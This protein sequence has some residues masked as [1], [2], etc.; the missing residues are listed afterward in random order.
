METGKTHGADA[1]YTSHL[2]ET[3]SAM[4]DAT[5]SRRPAGWHAT[6]R[7]PLATR[8]TMRLMAHAVP[9]ETT[10]RHTAPH[11]ARRG[12]AKCTHR[13]RV[14]GE[15]GRPTTARRSFV[16]PRHKTPISPVHVPSTAAAVP[17]PTI[18]LLS[19]VRQN[20]SP[21]PRPLRAMPAQVDY[22]PADAVS[23]TGSRTAASPRA[24]VV[25]AAG[26]AGTSRRYS[27]RSSAMKAG[28]SPT[29]GLCRR[30][31]KKYRRTTLQLCG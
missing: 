25:P 2:R 27:T 20:Q 19:T 14:S 26:P 10:R 9:H 30:A 29:S 7:K 24:T 23:M 11:G 1:E 17:R 4:P 5:I 8:R 16:L 6:R 22:S 21:A 13:K 12:D 31:Q 3:P 28:R 15:M 18:Q